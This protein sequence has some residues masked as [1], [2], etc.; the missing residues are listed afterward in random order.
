MFAIKELL[1]KR[2]SKQKA[3]AAVTWLAMGAETVCLQG[4]R[5]L[6][7]LP[8]TIKTRPIVSTV[9]ILSSVSTLRGRT[10]TP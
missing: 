8:S 7:H 1:I 2:E 3:I 6:I 10:P 5:H 9:T 4:R